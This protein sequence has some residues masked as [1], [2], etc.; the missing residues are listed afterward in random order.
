MK[1]RI[2]IVLTLFGISLGLSAQTSDDDF[3][4]PLVEVLEELQEKYQVRI[5]YDQRNI[6]DFMLRFADW[7]MVPG[8]LE[9]SL[10]NV[11]APFDYIY[12]KQGEGIYK[13]SAFRYHLITPEAGA[14]A[15][16]YLKTQYDD[17][18]SWEIRKKELQ[19]CIREAIG[20]DQLPRVEKPNAILSGKRKYKGYTIENI[21]L[22][23][24]PGLYVTG[25]IYR[26][27]KPK[28]KM[29]VIITPNGHFG[30]GRYRADEQ[31]RCAALAKMGALVVSYD[32][33]GW[34]ES[35]LQV[36][37]TAHRKSIA[38]TIQT[39]NAIS[40]LDYL[41]GLPNVDTSRVGITGG[42]GGGSQTMLVSAIDP[43]I[44]V[45]VPVVM[46]SSFHSGGCPCE[47][48]MPIH[49]C[50]EKTNNAEMAALFA[51]KPQLIISDGKDWTMQVP[52][53]EYPFIKRTYGFYNQSERV[54]NAH[55]ED[56]GHDYGFS[57]RKAM[58]TFMARHLTLDLKAVQGK[59]SEID[60]SD[61]TIEAY[62]KMHVFG[63][64]GEK[65]PEGAI[66]SLEELYEV[67][68]KKK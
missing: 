65:L 55:F 64:S 46:T 16:D 51:P 67:L 15:L 47:S 37:A 50:G 39:N 26:P 6:G 9:Q 54:E 27:L 12:V 7:R 14:A 66:T 24:I 10:K 3:Q 63:E 8:D 56:E 61:I 52:D 42:S 40:L 43:R 2:I 11:L 33:F 22:E 36:P 17:K 18:E 5:K 23:T 68:A 29:P 25:S 20:I 62:S 57:K 30:D 28:G 53:V 60:E 32:L 19:Q 21:A 31:L 1:S 38:H 35:L 13:I 48:G 44:S 45:S 59:S 34:G 58:Y 49:L 41:L 4:R